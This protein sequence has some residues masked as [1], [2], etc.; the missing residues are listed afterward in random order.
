MVYLY[1]RPL[2]GNIMYNEPIPLYK[3]NAEDEEQRKLYGVSITDTWSLDSYLARFFANGLKMMAASAH[4]YPGVEPYDGEGG[5]EKWQRD[6]FLVANKLEFYATDTTEAISE[7]I[8]WSEDESDDLLES[9]NQSEEEYIR[10]WP[11]QHEYNIKTDIVD[12]VQRQYRKEAFAWLD[13]WWEA[14]WD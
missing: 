3:A 14:L 6:L 2:Q 8:D 4:A 9:L 11:A 10:R 7:N 12:E 1:L 13:K 5:F